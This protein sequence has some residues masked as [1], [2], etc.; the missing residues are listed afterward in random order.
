MVSFRSGFAIVSFRGGFAMVSF[1]SGFV[2]QSTVSLLCV[3]FE[4]RGGK[5]WLVLS[6]YLS[7]HPMEKWS[8][9]GLGD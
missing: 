3:K 6:Q 7:V 2:S 5:Y 9:P 8:A 4:R 1:R